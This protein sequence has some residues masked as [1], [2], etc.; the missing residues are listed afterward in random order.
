V[1]DEH[2]AVGFFILF[3]DIALAGVR[4]EAA[5]V[6]RQHVDPRLA[7]D[8]PLGELPAGAAGGGDAEAVALVEPY[9]AQPPGGSDERAAIGAVGD[10]SID[11]VLDAAVLQRRHPARGG[12]D[13]RH[14]AIEIAGKEAAPE[15]V[16]NAVCKARRRAALVRTEDPAHALLA[17]VIGLVGLAQH[18]ELAPAALA[19]R[20]QLGRLVV[21]DV[22]VLDR[23][24]RH[25]Q[26]QQLSALPGVVTS[27]QHQMLRSDITL[28][29]AHPPLTARSALHAE[30]LG[31]LVDLGART[32]R[33]LAQCHG[34]IGGRNVAVVRVVE[35]A[36]DGGGVEAAAELDERPE[37]LDPGR[38]DDFEGHADGVGRAAIFL[39]LVHA[40]FA[41]CEAQIAGDVKAHVLAGLRG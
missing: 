41:G 12:L 4:A 6:H 31:M 21:D 7:L 37:L 22:L 36:D 13:V 15:P 23:D 8:D 28:A 35:G 24:R 32:A 9:V 14:Q 39:V 5:R 3:D 18:G 10:R 33:T 16:G 17:Q 19:V 27:R 1:D 34:E 38:T 30:R 40:L 20:L 11:D 25:V 2:V 29:G 26:T